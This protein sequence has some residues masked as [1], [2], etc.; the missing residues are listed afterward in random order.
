[1]HIPSVGCTYTAL[2][3]GGSWRNGIRLPTQAGCANLRDAVVATGFSSSLDIRVTQLQQLMCVLEV[4]RDVRC[5]GAA[6]VELCVVAAGELDA[7]YE[8]DLRLWDVAAG[9]L[10]AAEAG[11]EVAGS[12]LAGTGTL[13]AAPP[14]L[15][16]PLH[17]LV[18]PPCSIS[19]E[20]E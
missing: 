3:G 13:V 11:I 16:D 19:G 20:H 1:V 9:A 7:Y 2:A 8:S 17:C 10:V 14:R 15:A 5:H 4:V 12:P 18:A 6:S